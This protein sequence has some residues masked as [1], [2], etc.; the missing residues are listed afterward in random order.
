MTLKAN[1]ALYSVTHFVLQEIAKFLLLNFQLIHV[2]LFER[3]SM[4]SKLELFWMDFRLRSTKKQRK[5]VFKFK[6]NLAEKN[7]F[8]EWIVY[9]QS[10]NF[11][12]SGLKLPKQIRFKLYCLLCPN[13]C[14]WLPISQHRKAR[15]HARQFSAQCTRQPAHSMLDCLAWCWLSRQQFCPTAHRFLYSTAR[16]HCLDHHKTECA[17]EWAM[18]W[19]CPETSIIQTGRSYAITP[20]SM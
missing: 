6:L 7:F 17:L 9:F 12:Q 4:K 20:F 2:F 8:F 19:M 18:F 1:S 13:E 3:L 11:S 14:A 15:A 16:W 10:Q 5:L